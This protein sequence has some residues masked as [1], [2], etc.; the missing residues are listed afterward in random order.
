MNISVSTCQM[1]VRFPDPK[2]LNDVKMLGQRTIM[3]FWYIIYDSLKF[4]KPFTGSYAPAL[5]Q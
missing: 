1:M 3:V 2:V 5:W 4:P